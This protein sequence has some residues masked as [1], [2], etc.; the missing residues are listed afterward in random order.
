M[1]KNTYFLIVAGIIALIIPIVPKVLQLRILVLRKLR[2]KSLADWH[3]RGSAGIIL[4]AR[5][6]L[7]ALAIYLAIYGL[8]GIE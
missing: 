5:I 6:I 8:W 7:A 1:D 4:T 2:L 3:E